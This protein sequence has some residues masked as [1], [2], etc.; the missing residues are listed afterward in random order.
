MRSYSIKDGHLF[1]SGML[2]G[3]SYELAPLTLLRSGALR[4]EAEDW[5]RG[6]G[7]NKTAGR[8]AL[9]AE[10]CCVFCEETQK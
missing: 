2:A 3:G 5:V 6:R 7:K 1:L 4:E 8:I 10:N 9:Q